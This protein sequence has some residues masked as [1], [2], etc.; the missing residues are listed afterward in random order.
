MSVPRVIPS[1][2]AGYNG[3][4]VNG[5]CFY[6]GSQKERDCVRETACIHDA[7]VRRGQPWVYK[8]NLTAPDEQESVQDT[9][10]EAVA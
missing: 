3:C 1:A 5:R 2:E 8:P 4:I 6:E 9:P 7:E 10:D